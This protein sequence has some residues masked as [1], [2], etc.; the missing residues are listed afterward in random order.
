[1]SFE[2]QNITPKEAMFCSL[3]LQISRQELQF[4]LL[5][6]GAPI[7]SGRE[8]FDP[9]RPL[10]E[11]VS[12]LI[13]SEELLQ[14]PYNRVCLIPVTDKV[15]LV[16]SELAA[17]ESGPTYLQ[18]HE[19]SVRA[20]DQIIFSHA[21]EGI[22]A[23]TILSQ[24]LWQEL[25]TLY[26]QQLQVVHPLQIAASKT[27]QKPTIEINFTDD[28]ANIAIKDVQLQYCEM[29]PCAETAELLFYL[30]QL[31]KQYNLQNYDLLIT[32]E[33]VEQIRKILK[34][35]RFKAHIDKEL[36][37]RLPKSLRDEE[38]NYNNLIYCFN[39]HH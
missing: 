10:S 38:T 12:Q 28:W 21:T 23:Y 39:A 32:G 18:A 20:D 11:T 31:D 36:Y 17:V 30:Q 34:R 1:M 37:S 27:H 13:R 9:E 7:Q 5:E 33:R 3:A 4:C 16:P 19:I 14:L 15:C 8:E 6:S 35:Y 26:G 24:P 22:T 25:Q 29:L 2:S